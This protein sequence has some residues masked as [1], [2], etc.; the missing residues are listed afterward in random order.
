MAR[1]ERTS[2]R[3]R[4]AVIIG[5]GGSVD[6]VPPEFWRR[7]GW[8]LVGTNRALV[9]RALEHRRPDVMVARD[10]WDPLWVTG[11]HIGKKYYR[12]YWEPF[13]GR[14][15]AEELCWG[16][17]HEVDYVRQEP[18]WQVVSDFNR[19]NVG[20]VMENAS[21]VLMAV[22]WAFHQGV[23]EFELIGVDYFGGHAEI[24][25]PFDKYDTG[26]GRYEKRLKK[27]DKIPPFIERQ[28]AEMVRGVE[29][30]GGSIVN[31]SPG[32]RLQSVPQQEWKVDENGHEHRVGDSR[33]PVAVYASDTA[34]D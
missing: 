3:T 29:T 31:R 23:R 27:H 19:D 4:R 5:N 24:I 25:P 9:F 2:I 34:V 6:V 20:S 13:G 15:V 32:T 26:G 21:V 17:D 8:L 30:G 18:G 14:K 28:F 33:R 7:P 11:K 16:G 1:N 12:E 22:N 10:R